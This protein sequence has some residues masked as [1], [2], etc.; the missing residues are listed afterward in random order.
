MHRAID[1]HQIHDLIEAEGFRNVLGRNS[2]ASVWAESVRRQESRS[3]PSYRGQ[4][5]PRAS[6]ERLEFVQV[7][8]TTRCNFNC[9]YC[10]GRHL[11]QRDMALEVF[12]GFL[13]STQRISRIQLQGEG[14]PLMH[15]GFYEMVERA[16]ARHPA[17]RLSTVTNGSLLSAHA[18]RLVESALDH[19]FV[20]IDTA[21]PEL[22]EKIRRGKL[23]RVVEGM[24][25]L[26][27][28]RTSRG[29]DRPAVGV[30]VTV[31]RRTIS[32]LPG[33]AALYE[34]L[35]LDGGLSFQPL[36]AMSA[37][38]RH[39]DEELRSELLSPADLA[40]VDRVIMQDPRTV[41]VLRRAA[42]AES[43][44]QEPVADCACE[45][46]TCAWLE[47]GLYVCVDGTAVACCFQKDSR[48]NGL[49]VFGHT[50]AAEILARRAELAQLLVQGI[51]PPGCEGCSIAARIVGVGSLAPTTKRGCW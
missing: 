31:L 41:A 26:V 29:L 21:E 18:D 24:K 39:Y 9:G 44:L 11:P 4:T 28:A 3:R 46:S 34:T 42:R 1:V 20:S 23:D 37:Y 45:S 7:E 15:P 16:R 25:A 49:G 36:Q 33:V 10:A 22:F 47:R 19:V 27:A 50:S 38:T 35:G 14:E 17:V 51:V 43:A 12:D 30:A 48:R 2:F 13:S 40:D 6:N 8:P 5:E 32:G